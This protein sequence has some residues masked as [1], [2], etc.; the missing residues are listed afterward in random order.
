MSYFVPL[1]SGSSLLVHPPEWEGG[2]RRRG[3]DEDI[4]YY[5]VFFSPSGSGYVY[6]RDRDQDAGDFPDFCSFCDD[7]VR[8]GYIG[9]C[10]VPAVTEFLTLD[11]ELV[12][13]AASVMLT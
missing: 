2:P 7:L 1:P 9:P 6:S 13:V 10:D 5:M 12:S 11:P 8:E 4:L 3:P